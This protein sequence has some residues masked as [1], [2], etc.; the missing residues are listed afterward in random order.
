MSNTIDNTKV[1]EDIKNYKLTEFT[2]TYIPYGWREFF[3]LNTTK[4]VLINIE[5]NIQKDINTGCSIIPPLHFIWNSFLAT[6]YDKVRVVFVGQD[7]YPTKDIA[8]G[9][10]F[11]CW[12]TIP[13]E[14]KNIFKLCSETIKGFIP[15]QIADF[16]SWTNQGVLMINSG[17]TY[18][19]TDSTNDKGKSHI[20][21][22]SHF[23]LLLLDYL[24]KKKGLVFVF[25]GNEAKKFKSNIDKNKHKVL[26]TSHPSSKSVHFGF[27]ESNI[28]NKINNY[29][30]TP[31]D[32][33]LE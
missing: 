25:F 7:P 4:Q 12:T 13:D 8:S 27:A 3:L 29:L 30:S 32:W 31:I 6:P 28:F 14:A 11:Q 26:D 20:R 22:W 1:E 10:A 15:P 19:E 16:S 5:K 24:C 23:V 2:N 21:I 9:M 33:R 17:F 18:V